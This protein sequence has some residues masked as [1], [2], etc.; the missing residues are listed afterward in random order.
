[1]YADLTQIPNLC[2][3]CVAPCLQCTSVSVCVSCVSGFLFYRGGC[4]GV[5]PVGVTVERGGVC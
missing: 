3:N 5:C 4:L 2:V 1:M